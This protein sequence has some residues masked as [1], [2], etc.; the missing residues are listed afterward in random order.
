MTHDIVQSL[1]LFLSVIN[2]VLLIISHIFFHW[3][4]FS[5]FHI[6]S[7]IFL[8][9]FLQFELPLLSFFFFF[10]NF[11]FLY[12]F[13]IRTTG[14]MKKKKIYLIL[15]FESVSVI[16]FPLLLTR[17]IT[18][19]LTL[20][21]PI[22]GLFLWFFN[23]LNTVF[24][25]F[26]EKKY[27]QR[28]KILIVIF[29]QLINI[30]LISNL[31]FHNL[32]LEI[33]F[34]T[35][36][37]FYFFDNI[38]YIYNQIDILRKLNIKFKEKLM[39]SEKEYIKIFENSPAMYVFLDSSF[40]IIECNKKFSEAVGLTVENILFRNFLDFIPDIF[41]AKIKLL[42]NYLKYHSSASGE[43]A[44]INQRKK[45]SIDVFISVIKEKERSFIIM[46]D[47]TA[48]KWMQ[49]SLTSYV[50]QLKTEMEHSK[51]ADKMKSVFL[52]NMS[53]EIRT[54]L[55]SIIGFSTLLKETPLSS[56]QLDY[57]SKVIGSGEHLLQIINDIIDLSKIEAGKMD[58]EIES[59]NL[60]KLFQE[61]Y[62]IIYPQVF[63]KK[64][65]FSIDIQEEIQ[66]HYVLLD[67]FRMKQVLINLLS[68]SVKFT[69]T[70]FISVKIYI[71]DDEL[72]FEIEDTG[73]GIAKEKQQRVFEPFVQAEDTL[74]RKYGGTGL[75]LAIT[76][77]LVNLME[78]KIE[79]FSTEGKGTRIRVIFSD[80][81]LSQ[82]IEDPTYIQFGALEEEISEKTIEEIKKEVKP[83]SNNKPIL[84]VGED[85]DSVYML[86]DFILKKNNITV[87]RA[88]NGNE[89]L[90]LFEANRESLKMILLDINLPEID[91]ITLAR[92]I[93]ERSVGYKVVGFSAYY[94]EE[95]KDKVQGVMDG[96]IKKPFKVDEIYDLIRK[97][98]Q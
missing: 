95:V 12:Y 46:Q 31:F 15:I 84:L 33:L 67:G 49:N 94:Y 74:D 35:V 78:G 88:A 29:L 8:W 87:V 41:K 18:G 27:R 89:V 71:F 26:L 92:K 60:N 62:N 1:I 80:S 38:Y 2:F 53:H 25:G 6:L 13:L 66:K 24:F 68:N 55:T 37:T 22:S 56:L 97:Y 83:Y 47:I 59:V 3:K 19:E 43:F 69:E 61:V 58:I 54:P 63:K 39:V 91:G 57:I 40:K 64:L 5:V 32:Y 7:F 96:Y 48:I 70:G 11:L 81:V 20:F 79:L 65:D 36:F 9:L 72:I 50:E 21:P 90:S 4:K 51:I 42:K 82:E 52:A 44:L 93:K 86:L 77:R 85:D 14:E 76:Q 45:D 17:F 30:S 28:K 16:L 73:I 10:L 75:G 34:L 23:F 98:L